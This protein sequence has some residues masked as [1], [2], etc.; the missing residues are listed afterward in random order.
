MKTNTLSL[1]EIYILEN[2]AMPD[3]VKIGYTEIGSE[4]RA[5]ELSLVTGIP[6]PFNV[7][8]S[9]VVENPKQIE[10]VIHRHLD[11]YRV[12]KS[13]EFFYLSK[14]EAYSEIGYVFFKTRDRKEIFSKL[15]TSLL[16]LGNKYP[17]KFGC[18]DRQDFLIILLKSIEECCGQNALIESLRSLDSSEII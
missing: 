4:H 16:R 3:M 1:G 5:A 15:L 12:N 7:A 13:R 14:E 8:E 10:K 18:R 9:F 17:E 2:A 6:L 11:K